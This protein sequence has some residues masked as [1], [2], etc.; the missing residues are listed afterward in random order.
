MFAEPAQRIISTNPSAPAQ[1]LPPAVSITYQSS[2]IDIP[3]NSSYSEVFSIPKA[4]T[5]AQRTVRKRREEKE[6]LRRQRQLHSD[7]PKGYIAYLLVVLSIVYIVDE[8]TS[9]I[10]SSIQSEVVMD[11]FLRGMVMDF[12]A[13]LATLN[14]MTLPLYSMILLMPFYKAQADRY[15]RK[16]FLVLN[17]INSSNFFF[18]TVSVLPENFFLCFPFAESVHG[19]IRKTPRIKGFPL[20][21]GVFWAPPVGLE[22]TT[23]GLTGP[24]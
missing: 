11:F 1:A 13:G 3:D 16:P 14:A 15:G 18:T 19:K 17:T 9:A 21:L 5:P 22:P 8:I 12:N 23:C 2:Q 24:V 10:C 7:A 6:L 4:E 20:F